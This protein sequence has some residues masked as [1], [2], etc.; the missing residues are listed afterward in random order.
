VIP[1]A[2]GRPKSAAPV[3][4][5]KPIAVASTTWRTKI[6][7]HCDCKYH[8]GERGVE[9]AQVICMIREITGMLVMASAIANT[10]N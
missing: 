4:P 3:V 8:S 5:A 1:S 9:D 10:T 6:L 2:D 7:E